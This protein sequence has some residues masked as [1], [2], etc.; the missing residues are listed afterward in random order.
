MQVHKKGQNLSI[1]FLKFIDID[2]RLK[3]IYTVIFVGYEIYFSILIKYILFIFLLW[4]KYTMY[5]QFNLFYNKSCMSFFWRQLFL[6]LFYFYTPVISIVFLYFVI[7]I[8]KLHLK[9]ITH[10]TYRY[11][12]DK[13]QVFK[14]CLCCVFAC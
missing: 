13:N 9:I 3:D 7:H 5:I 8:K 4:Y 14:K 12:L 10:H 2:V 6:M 11:M 1:I